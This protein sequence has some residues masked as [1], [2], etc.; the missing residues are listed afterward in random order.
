MT[1]FV[2]EEVK[3]LREKSDEEIMRVYANQLLGRFPS[4]IVVDAIG[5]IMKERKI[6]AKELMVSLNFVDSNG[7]EQAINLI[8]V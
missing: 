1:K 5:K 7:K 4:T 6:E 3:R 8:E 2:M